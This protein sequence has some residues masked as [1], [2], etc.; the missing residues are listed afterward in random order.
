MIDE[1]C[2]TNITAKKGYLS[3]VL[4]AHLPFVKHPE[5]SSFLEERWYFEAMNGTYIPLI[6]MLKRLI[7]E[8][9]EFELTLSLSPTLLC[10]MEDKLLSERYSAH[11][12]KL[13]ELAKREQERN[14]EHGH[15]KWLADYYL[16]TFIEARKIFDECGHRIC[17]HFRNLSESKKVH[18]ITTSAT[19]AVLPLIMSEPAAVRGQIETGLKTFCNVFG[20]RPQGFWLPECAFHPGIEEYMREAGIRYFFLESHGIDHADVLPLYGVYAP[21]FTPS[22]VA[23][24]S[25]DQ[26]STEEVWSAQKGY[27]G[28]PEYRE[29]Y[30]DIGHELDIDYIRPYI[31][32]NVRV[33]TGIKYWRITGP[34]SQKD[35]YNPYRA[36][37][38]AAFH[39]QCFYDK[40]VAQAEYLAST[41]GRPPVIVATFDAELFGHWWYEGPQ[42]L[43][44][45]IRRI[46]ADNS[47]LALISPSTYL[48]Q[49]PVHQRGAPCMS[50]WGHRGYFEVWCN[51]K[52][53]WIL[54]HIHECI[55]RMLA[56]AGRFGTDPAADKR[57]ALNQCMRELLLAQ[58]SDWPFMITNATSGQYA[59]R[60]V[61]DHV[62][63][64]HFLAD[65]LENNSLDKESVAALEYLDSAFP[66]ADYR[67]FV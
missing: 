15:L 64:F 12:D 10:M 22:G 40:R 47:R 57:R 24:F 52:N 31:A 4:H 43:E 32:D 50:S 49:H 56:L 23:A 44:F 1:S 62:S 30:R 63:R 37:E 28:D 53:D 26:A 54:R 41:M 51:G 45:L 17:N 9:V 19:H 20:Y 39:A 21:L 5:Y 67:V 35:F 13:I 42:W 38:R 59:S 66:D 48:N 2:A 33:D 27:P 65:G 55:R 3:I 61:C 60:R 16:E 36:R 7:S 29:F 8:N 14:R 25:R 46:A 58:S 34:R 11:L 18:L 6:A